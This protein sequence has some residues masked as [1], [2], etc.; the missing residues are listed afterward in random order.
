M[1]V[2]FLSDEEAA[3]FGRYRGPPTQAD[4]DRLFFLDD[5]D[6]A[7]VSKRRLDHMRLGF[8]SQLVT[9]RYLGAFPVDVLDV[10]H[11][12]VEYLAE[13][14][15]VEDPS[16]LKLYGERAQTRLEHAWTIQ[17]A[18]GL[19][20]F[21][22]GRDD[23]ARWIEARSWTTGDGPKLIF[24]DAVEWLRSRGVLLP[25]V[26]VLA[27]LVASVRDATTARLYDTVAD[28]LTSSQRSA[29]DGL[30]VV[31]DGERVCDLERLR[32]SPA[33]VSG[34]GMVRALERVREI[35][36]LAMPDFADVPIRRL[37]EL[38]R[39]GLSG[40]PTS[41]RRHPPTRRHATLAAS[42]RFLERKA[43]DDA[44]ELLDLLVANELV[45]TA[46]R[47]ADNEVLRTHARLVEAAGSLRAAVTVLFDGINQPERP[48][49]DEL[50]ASIG[51]VV[52]MDTLERAVATVNELVPTGNASSQDWRTVLA[53]R[54]IVTV[55]GF[56][57]ILT[58]VIDF[59]ADVG[60]TRLLEALSAVP[61]VLAHRRPL[62][63]D[64]ID[65]EIVPAAWQPTVFAGNDRND[66]E[67]DRNAYLYC[68]LVEFQRHLKRRGV[69]APASTRWTDPRVSL[70][71]GEQWAR[72]KPEVLTALAL[73]ETPTGF[74]AE[75]REAL[76]AAY[77]RVAA[78]LGDTYSDLTVDDRGRVHLTA[79]NAIPEPDSL[80]ALR[81]TVAAMLPRVDLSQ[82]VLEVMGWEPGF[83]EAFRSWSGSDARLEGLDISIAAC[84]TAQAMNVGYGAMV[85]RGNPALIRDRLSHVAQTYITAENIAAANRPLIERQAG[86]DFAG[87]LGGGLVAAVDGMRFVVPTQTIHA[88]PN[89][90]YF[91]RRKGVTWLNMINDQAIGLGAKVVSGTVR[92]SLHVIDV[93]HNQDGGQRPDII[94]TDTAS[95]SD[96]VFGLLHLLGYSYRPELA[97][98]P[99]QKMWTIG[100]PPA[101]YGSLTT[102]ARGRISLARIEQ[103]WPDMLRIAGS[104]HSGAVRAYDIVRMLQRDGRPTPLGEATN[105]YGR[106]FKSMHM[107]ECFDDETYRRD[108][109]GIRN[110]Q[111]GRH[112]LAQRI[113]H[114]SKGE[115]FQRYHDGMEDQLG[116]LG[117]VVN[118]VVLWN[119]YYIDLAIKQ[120]RAQGHDINNEDIARLSPYVRKHVNVHGTYSFSRPDTTNTPRPLRD[121]STPDPDID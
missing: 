98:M 109:K 13:Q 37:I 118:C 66:G 68:V 87:L 21:A 63:A 55:S 24:S 16:C 17:E 84:L 69:Y 95:Y 9:V 108:I 117:L 62:N 19:V 102:A 70:L 79:L 41:L 100:R 8:A 22:A 36:D 33:T 18:L 75:H 4:L 45:G 26:S 11:R 72:A 7:L 111:E 54:R 101:A 71:D 112:A 73:P 30:L 113:F 64:D 6:R 32:R 44:L 25:G 51:Q 99:D 119:T 31:R 60:S 53:D 1:P 28:S 58:E 114:G 5:A 85:S 115:L 104:I 29:L 86:I 81:I 12:V 65:E 42:V 116:A 83:V 10:P 94:V 48:T 52:P 15:G 56:L 67:I 76:D 43:I 20:D 89:Q 2:E 27:R 93:V 110:L 50:C 3:G 90:R 23:L 61:A 47:T 80:A 107:L 96:L 14:L 97:D 35:A 82:I 40:K 46:V 106:I 103:H 91:G 74:L 39:Y 120:L 38:S 77:R 34:P 57:S 121:P 88:R 59:D 92:D 49:L 105:A 78:H